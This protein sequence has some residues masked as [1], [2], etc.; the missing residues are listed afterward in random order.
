MTPVLVLI[1]QVPALAAVSSD[2]V[3]SLL[4]KPFGGALHF[5]RGTVRMDIVLWL[6]LSS[7]PSAFLGVLLQAVGTENVDH[8]LKQGIGIALLASAGSMVL[9]SRVQSLRMRGAALAPR[10]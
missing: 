5:R 9:R 3:T 7:V 4:M 1:F 10:S 8:F 6:L 2:L